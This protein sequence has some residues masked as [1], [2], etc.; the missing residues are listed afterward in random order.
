MALSV[1]M[2]KSFNTG[3]W[4]PA[5][6]ARVDIDKYHSGAALLRNFFVDYRGGASTRTGTQYILQAFKS[7]AAV[8]LIPFQ[9]STAVSYILEF[10][11]YYVRFFYN[12]APILESAFNIA[13]IGLTNPIQVYIP[14]HNYSVGDW[15][16]ISG[17]G[18]TT[19]LNGNYYRVNSLIGGPGATVTLGDLN[20]GPIDG[21]GFGAYTSGGTTQRIYT[22]TTP[23]AAT[24]VNQIK[25]AQQVSSLI[26][27][28][29]NHP[30]Q[31]LS[32]VSY[33]NWTIGAINFGSSSSI[34]VPTSINTTLAGGSVNYSY[35]VT[36]FDAQGDES[37][38]SVPVSLLNRTDLRTTAGSISLA[39]NAVAGAVAYNV[40]KADVSYF[41]AIPGGVAYGFI[42]Q[43]TGNSIVDSNIVPDFNISPPVGTNP[44]QGTGVASVV[45]NTPGTYT[46]VPAVYFSGGGPN[47]NAVG[48]AVL[49]IRTPVGV[50]AGGSGYAVSDTISLG[51]GVILQVTTVSSGAVTGVSISNAGSL[52]VG[53]TPANP[54]AQVS[55]SGAGTGATFN[56]T[57]GVAQVSLVYAGVGYTSAPAVTFSP[58]GATATASLAAATTA[59]PSVPA[60]FQQRL[61]L[62]APVAQPETMDFSQPGSYFNFN[63]S[64]PIQNDDAISVTLASG[65]LE[66]VKSM[67]AT[68][69][70][71]VVFTDKS[72]WMVTG[73][74]LGSAISPTAIAANRQSYLG[75]NDVPPIMNNYDILY[76]GARGSI[77][78]DA[79]YNYYAQVFIGTDITQLSS[80]LF[81]G[82]QV[83]QWAWAQAPFKVV[84]CLRNDGQLLSLT[85]DKTE[86][87]TAWAHHDTQGSF[88]SV[89]TVPEVNAAANM[90]LDAVYV[91]V[92]RTI[93]GGQQL[94]YIERF[95]DRLYFGTVKNAWCVDAGI[96]YNGPP[97]SSLSG[98]QHLGGATVTGLADGNVIP[99]FVMPMS[100]SFTLSAPASNVTVGLSFLPQLQT[101]QI[102]IGEPTIQSR[103]K[104]I[105][106][107]AVR[108]VDTLGLQIGSDFADLVYLKDFTIGTVGSL[109]NKVVTDLVTGDGI[110]IIDPKWASQGQFC[111]QQPVPYPATITGV[112]PRLTTD[113]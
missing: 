109:T 39:W 101:L 17:V 76:V 61:V 80:H 42:G 3:E 26:L 59:N 74:F 106:S 2:Q 56:L 40:Y 60:F 78:Y 44:F 50:A 105:S 68:A 95:T 85:Y 64:S 35:E 90:T 73:G 51:N 72:S 6:Q 34:P 62:A 12:K 41:G 21:T 31:V 87:F 86:E 89:A 57:W 83:T 7:W 25:Y 71:L 52:S 30:A 70:G 107:V 92:Q 5:L 20:G 75:A 9:A 108:A 69:P 113:V 22:L 81:Y 33:N 111:I 93:Q 16:Y 36:A 94:R 29:P 96:N 15:I 19:Q 53:S 97:V 14:G 67:I 48:Q 66:S 84:W 37:I 100:G 110:A 63:V 10:G 103:Q 27:C 32:I 104:K 49:Q 38:A 88:M 11:D 43:V 18:G 65:Q 28:H 77:V 91:V 98:A 99:P 46:V 13:S 45:V 8:R 79:T 112:I 102:D 47:A 54:V 24:E 1:R 58:T 82:Y 4:A 23:F 55:T